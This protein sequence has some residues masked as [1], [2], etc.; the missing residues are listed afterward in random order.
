[1]YFAAIEISLRSIP[2][3]EHLLNEVQKNEI[4]S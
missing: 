3:K 4:P 2:E 1:M